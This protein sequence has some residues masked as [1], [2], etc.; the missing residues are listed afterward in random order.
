MLSVTM[1]KTHKH[2]LI[3]V[4]YKQTQVTQV[5]THNDCELGECSL[6]RK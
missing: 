3:I 6:S 5:H 1:L 2:K 4:V